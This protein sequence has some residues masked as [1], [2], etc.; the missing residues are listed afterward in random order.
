[1]ARSRWLLLLAPTSRRKVGRLRA[2]LGWPGTAR[3]SQ[4]KQRSPALPGPGA[5]GALDDAFEVPHFR[6]RQVHQRRAYSPGGASHDAHARFDDA[7][8]IATPAIAQ[9]DVGHKECAE[10]IIGRAPVAGFD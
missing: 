2:M 8:G 6:L 5:E 3:R 7:D 9:G 4:A 1:M 10:E